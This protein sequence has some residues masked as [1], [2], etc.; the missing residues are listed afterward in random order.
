MSLGLPS[1]QPSAAGA[2]GLALI[3]PGTDRQA[4][5]Q[6]WKGTN[7]PFGDGEKVFAT[8]VLDRMFEVTRSVGYGWE[9]EYENHSSEDL[10]LMSFFIFI[11]FIFFIASIVGIVCSVEVPFPALCCS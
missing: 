2:P 11:F 6:G 3:R 8:G 5:P 1:Q 9:G 7:L 4:L 10:C